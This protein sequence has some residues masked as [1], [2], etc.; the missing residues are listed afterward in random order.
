MLSVYV[1]LDNNDNPQGNTVTTA[2]IETKHTRFPI[3]QGV[4]PIKGSQLLT[5]MLAG[6]TLA[7]LGQIAG[8]LGLEGGG[9]GTLGK[10][11]NDLQQIGETNFYAVA[12]SV[13]VLAVIAGF[14]IFSVAPANVLEV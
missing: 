7:A 1:I 5:E 8:M 4:L 13:I 9:H 12:T 3:L 11:L 10:I 6:I 2:K 14:K